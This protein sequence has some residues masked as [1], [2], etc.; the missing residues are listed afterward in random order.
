MA[1][2]NIFKQALEEISEIND[3]S[4]VDCDE[5][6]TKLLYELND[7]FLEIQSIARAALGI[8][9]RE[10]LIF[11]QTADH[12]PNQFDPFPD[13][14]EKCPECGQSMVLRHGK[15]GDF[16]GCSGYPNCRHT[17]NIDVDEAYS[18]A[19]HKSDL[20]PYVP[21]SMK[22]EF[23]LFEDGLKNG[24]LND[25]METDEIFTGSHDVFGG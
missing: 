25:Q 8:A 3:I 13:E 18:P 11:D 14:V 6:L 12:T 10:E 1:D 21:D 17:R 16:Y 15:R 20:D 7:R 22:E 4:L 23:K 24:D 9:K 19:V 2:P 5:G